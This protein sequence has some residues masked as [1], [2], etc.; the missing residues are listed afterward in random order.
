MPAEL[1]NVTIAVGNSSWASV[2]QVVFIRAGGS[3]GSFEV[4]S[5]PDSTHIQITNLEDSSSG[6][7][8]TNSPAGTVF[9]S[10]ATVSPAGREGPSGSAGTGIVTFG[11]GSPEGAVTA[12][13]GRFYFKEDAPIAFWLKTS[14]SGNTGWTQLLSE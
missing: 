7:Y 11:N 10:G 5:I 13:T 8:A 4:A 12:P 1:A 14:G 6:A 3:V 9:A 2:G